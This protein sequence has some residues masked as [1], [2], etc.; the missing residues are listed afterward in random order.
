M[1]ENTSTIIYKYRKIDKRLYEM[2]SKHSLWFA[3][4][5]TFNDPFDCNL[6]FSV[7][8]T[9]LTDFVLDTSDDKNDDLR[10]IYSIYKKEL[11]VERVREMLIENTKKV[12]AKSGICCFNT[13]QR[14]L[15]PW[16]HYADS[17]KGVC[18]GFDYKELH[19]IFR[20]MRRVKYQDEYPLI[21]I[22][23]GV[24]EI[25]KLLITKSTHWKDEKEVRF[26]E[27]DSG[28]KQFSPTALKEVFFGV[29]AES[30]KINEVIRFL[31]LCGYSSTKF[32]KSVLSKSRF[33]I[34][35]YEI[36]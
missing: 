1:T 8:E 32:Y 5:A 28:Y 34:E 20:V 29:N 27:S 22:K 18:L 36:L 26:I 24:T 19:G 14:E 12:I 31:Q 7:D 33:E 16:A 23:G 25:V 17:H 35:Y 13:D 6:N 30:Q 9:A 15:L 4:P 11:G 21:D 10:N 2:L 3:N